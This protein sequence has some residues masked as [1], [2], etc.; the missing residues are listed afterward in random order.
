[1]RSTP[2][3]PESERDPRLKIVSTPTLTAMTAEVRRANLLKLHD[4]AIQFEG[5]ASN[6]GAVSLHRFVAFIEQLQRAGVDWSSAEPLGSDENA[7]RLTSVHKSKGLEYPIVFCPYGWDGSA[8]RPDEPV[9]FH[10]D[11]SDARLTVDL[12][13]DRLDTHRTLAQHELL[14]ENLRLLYVAVTRAKK[15]CYLAWGRIRSAETSAMAY[16]LHLG[17]SAGEADVLAAMRRVLE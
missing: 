13:S 3:F 10:A 5:F 6:Q 2:E 4:R 1:M 8:L 16:L 17:D 12:G 7:V 14:A 9:I 15:R 11:D